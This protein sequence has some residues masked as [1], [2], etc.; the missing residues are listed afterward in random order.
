[1]ITTP[2]YEA[3]HIL[4]EYLLFH[5]GEGEEILPYAFGPKE[6]LHFPVRCVSEFWGFLGQVSKS[7]RAL[8]L[9]CAV[10]RSSFELAR[11][12]HEVI[13]ID[14][15]HAFIKAASALQKGGCLRYTQIL[16]GTMK[17]P[18]T[19]RVPEGIDRGRVQFR[20]GDAHGLPNLLGSFDV[21]LA[22]NL[23]CRMADPRKL[24]NQLPS[25]VKPGSYLI[26]TTPYTW[27]ES[28]TPRQNWLGATPEA[29]DSL[30]V[31]EALLQPEFRCIKVK[32]LPFLIR[33]HARKF[34]WSVAQGSL[35]QKVQTS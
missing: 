21:V 22:A 26:L 25:L 10:G 34:Q 11:Y 29:G 1:M 24:L 5:Y 23:L 17:K 18:L 8:D 2:S 31:I 19:A 20:V 33:E 28:S 32:D 27:L 15:S 4:D 35:W 12:C 30:R 7:L 3:Q 9:G 14:A 6:A 13:G 16:T